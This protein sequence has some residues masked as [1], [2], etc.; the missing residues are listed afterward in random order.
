MN[1]RELITS[2]TRLPERDLKM[3]DALHEHRFLTCRQLACL[4]FAE[5]PDPRSGAA[6]TTVTRRV[7]QRRLAGLRDSGLIIRRALPRPGGGHENEPYYCLTPQGL[8]VV[9]WRHDLPIRSLRQRTGDALANPLFVRHALAG[10]DLHCALTAAARAHEGDRCE[11]EWWQGEHATSHNFSA[12]GTTMLLCPDGYTRYQRD[13]RLH[14]LLVEID[15]G[16]MT[17]QRLQAKL[18]RYQAYARSGA[19]QDSYPVFP[20]LLLLTTSS[21]RINTLH[22]RLGALPELVLLSATHDDIRR[23][24]PLAAIWQQPGRPQPR[25]LLSTTNE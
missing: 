4:H 11:P 12:R 23:Q 13:Q 24:G 16:T 14:H 20:K 9:G 22:D 7:A 6:V 21:R 10:A 1:D 15:L 19:W 18:D 25:P 8:R 2:A 5:H 3:L 17:I